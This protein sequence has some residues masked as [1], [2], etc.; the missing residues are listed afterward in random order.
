M[1]NL[2]V[3]GLLISIDMFLEIKTILRHFRGVFKKFRIFEAYCTIEAP[4][5]KLFMPSVIY[6]T[7]LASLSA[8]TWPNFI[9]KWPNIDSFIYPLFIL[10]T[11][12]IKKAS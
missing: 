10:Q 2:D 11:K 6:T 7:K 12:R 4:V 9:L 3:E 5:N 8:D 1:R